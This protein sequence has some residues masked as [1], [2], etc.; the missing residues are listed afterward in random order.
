MKSTAKSRLPLTKAPKLSGPGNRPAGSAV[1]AET[2]IALEVWFSEAG[3]LHDLGQMEGMIHV[4]R[5]GMADDFLNARQIGAVLWFAERDRYSRGPSSR[6]TADTVDVVFRVLGDAS[7]GVITAS[8]LQN[9]F[10]NWNFE[11]NL[12]PEIPGVIESI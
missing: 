2:P 6:G 8:F 9:E 7:N 1:F 11:A 12:P 10:G 3:T 4:H 5:H